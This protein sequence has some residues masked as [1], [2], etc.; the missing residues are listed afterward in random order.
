MGD[1]RTFEVTLATG[2]EAL[3][4]NLVFSYPEQDLAVIRLGRV[5]KGLRP[6]S[7]GD[8]TEV[9]VGQIVMAM[10]NSLGLSSS[11]TQ[12][13]VSAVGRTVTEGG[14]SG[15][16]A[17]LANMVQ[18][19]ASINPGDSGGALVNLDSEIIGISTPAVADPGLGRGAARRPASA[20]RSPPPRSST[21]PNRSSRLAR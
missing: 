21:S 1:A 4:A 12:G 14:Y 10:G 20:S 7:F 19:S 17:T 8:S 2:K 3:R 5:P 16:G 13:I 15:T 9:E 18:I 6:A 11:V